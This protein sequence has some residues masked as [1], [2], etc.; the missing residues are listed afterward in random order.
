ML[1]FQLP[2]GRSDRN[3]D[4]I[5]EIYT[6]STKTVRSGSSPPERCQSNSRLV[7]TMLLGVVTVAVAKV[8]VE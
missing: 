2:G 1:L 6:N 3:F 4:L 7:V 5:L 8:A